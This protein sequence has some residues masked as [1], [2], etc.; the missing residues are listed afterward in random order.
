MEEFTATMRPPAEPILRYPTTW[1]GYSDS[2]WRRA[3]CV[4]KSG[5]QR[6]S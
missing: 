4:A 3:A 6:A 5:S 1:A 2:R